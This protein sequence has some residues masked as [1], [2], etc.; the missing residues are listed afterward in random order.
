MAASSWTDR[1]PPGPVTG[2]QAVVRALL[3]AGVRVAFGM[4]GVDNLPIYDALADAPE[5]RHVLVR[6][7]QGAGFMA[8]GYARATRRV[9][10]VITTTGPGALNAA[11]PLAAS[12]ADGVPVLLIASQTEASLIGRGKGPSHDMRDQLGVFRSITG[13]ARR[14]TRPEAIPAAVHA[15][16][17]ATRGPR[18]G[19]AYLEIPSDVLTGRARAPFPRWHDR[20]LPRLEPGA[21]A[22]AA[23]CLAE[24]RRPLLLAGGGVRWSG[25]SSELAQL[26]ERLGAPVLTTT[27]GKGAIPET[28]PLS[29]GVTWSRWSPAAELVREAD[30]VLAVGTRLGAVDT[31]RWS[32]P[33]PERLVH[34]DLD[35]AEVGRNYPTALGLVGDARAGLYRLLA[36]AVPPRRPWVDVEACRGR[37]LAP[38]ADRP[39]LAMVR[40][41]RAAIPERATVVNDAPTLGY[42][43]GACWPAPS[44]DAFVTAGFG[45]LG[46]GLPAALGVRAGAP[47]RP[48]VALCGDGGLLFSAQELATAVRE[49]LPVV[50]LLINDGAYGSVRIIQ[51][52]Q[53]GGRTS[54]VELTNPDFL[55]FA[56]S[57][58]VQATR[59]RSPR[60]V[61]PALA[62]ALADG[63]CHLIEVNAA[64]GLPPL[65]ATGGT[66]GTAGGA[67]V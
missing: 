51:E 33:L 13:W 40:R 15:A 46:F 38:V 21:V 14:V 41:L 39:E 4:P 9:G 2:G 63:C 54:Q 22:T 35:P 11:T 32:L 66:S 26:A 16:L 43:V 27:A 52:Q 30:L 12:H 7:E 48:V 42:W 34:L 65:G 61:G 37:A 3:D 28:H 23:A 5:L 17:R 25:A 31:A 29:F 62:A 36:A 6:H 19:P 60:D 57:F 18:P 67:E 44:P 58:G 56:R 24:S 53:Y 47:D 50:V 10:V 59:V 64:Y 55:A 20:R 49:R 45:S 8:D 1:A